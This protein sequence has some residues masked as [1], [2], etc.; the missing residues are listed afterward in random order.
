MGT[1]IKAEL[2][3]HYAAYDIGGTIHEARII[4]TTPDSPQVILEFPDD[5]DAAEVRRRMAQFV[6][7]GEVVDWRR[8]HDDYLPAWI[9]PSPEALDA[10]PFFEIGD[11][12][13]SEALR[14]LGQFGDG[15]LI[16]IVDTGCWPGHACFDGVDLQGVD[17]SVDLQDVIGHGTACASILAGRLVTD[18]LGIVRDYGIAREARLLMGRGLDQPNGSGSEATIANKLRRI[19]DRGC[20]VISLS[21]G[22]S[23]SQV[24]DAAVNYAKSKGA[25][26]IAAAGNTPNA[27]IGSPARAADLVVLACDRNRS[28]ASFTSGTNWSTVGNRLTDYGVRIRSASKGAREGSFE[29]DGTSAA[30]PH[31]GGKAACLRGAGLDRQQIIGYLLGHRVGPPTVGIGELAADYGAAPG[32][33]GNVD[34]VRARLEAIQAA[35]DRDGLRWWQI[36][37]GDSRQDVI[38]F[39]VDIQASLGIIWQHAEEAKAV[40]PKVPPAPEPEPPPLP[41]PAEAWTDL[42]HSTAG[43]AG[44][45]KWLAGSTGVDI[46]VPRN[47]LIRAPFDGQMTFRKVAGGPMPIGEMVITHQDGR[48]VRWRH[49]EAIGGIGSH[50]RQGQD[51]AFVYDPS[52][53]FLRWPAGYPTPPDSYQHVDVSLASHPSRLNP[54]GGAGGDV[55]ADQHI[56]SQYGGVANITLIPRTPG[57]PEGSVRAADLEAW[58]AW[59]QPRE[60][61]S[62]C[63]KS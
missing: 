5:A 28:Y 62:P 14:A 6:A 21:L 23:S 29:W 41:E 42:L 30:C 45:S 18:S 1:R 36:R 4:A 15:V 10:E 26:V 22:G 39:A 17:G 8:E 35:C 16:G 12:Y 31:V 52:M 43:L 61:Q 55:D 27:A 60:E 11:T 50:V 34:E 38:A 51:V 49:V 44:R 7:W 33:G 54:Q 9:P 48:T 20:Q 19:A 2:A 58:T 63:A 32:E 24:I 59:A 3:A 13:P 46:F 37:D 25:V 53:D 40:L 57:P 47:T 56:W